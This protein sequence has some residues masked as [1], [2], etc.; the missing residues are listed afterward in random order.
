ML[1]RED[2]CLREPAF[3]L[4]ETTF[5]LWRQRGD[6]AWQHGPVDWPADEPDPD[7]SSALLAPL[8]GRPETYAAWAAEYFEHDVPLATVRAV[9]DHRPLDRDLVSTLTRRPLE[10]LR[11][12]AAEIGYPLPRGR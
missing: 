7:G 5:C 10:A 1:H 8:D 6:A 12:D 3:V 2:G 9:Y 11:A 4:E